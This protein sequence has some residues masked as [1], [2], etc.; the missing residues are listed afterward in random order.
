MV[1]QINV[2]QAIKNLEAASILM[3]DDIRE[4]IHSD[5]RADDA[6]WFLTEYCV[7]H[8]EKFGEVFEWA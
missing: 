3:D 6:A 5:V 7:R 1:N 2:A 8:E 4:T